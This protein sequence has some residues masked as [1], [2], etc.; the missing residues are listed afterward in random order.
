MAYEVV[1]QLMIPNT[2]I[3]EECSQLVTLIRYQLGDPNEF[4]NNFCFKA[5]SAFGL[6]E[7]TQTLCD[8]ENTYYR[9][10]ANFAWVLLESFFAGGVPEMK[11]PIFG[12]NGCTRHWQAMANFIRG[13]ETIADEIDVHLQCIDVNGSSIRADITVDLHRGTEKIGADM[14]T[15]VYFD[16]MVGRH[17][18]FTGARKRTPADETVD[19]DGFAD[20]YTIQGS[21]SFKNCCEDRRGHML[22]SDYQT[23][24]YA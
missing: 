20:A 24:F 17:V 12:L 11:S 7:R 10:T 6:V 9:H 4:I 5:G 8:D 1:Q 3:F 14:P 15:H 13:S 2:R 16:A 21:F 22:E 23:S 18:I 19:P